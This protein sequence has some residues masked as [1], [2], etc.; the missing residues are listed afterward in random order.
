[1]ENA[2]AKKDI[3]GGRRE[4]RKKAG[5]AYRSTC[6]CNAPYVIPGRARQYI[7]DKNGQITVVDSDPACLFLMQS[8]MGAKRSLHG[9][10]T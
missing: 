5:R 7:R 8:V 10:A 9:F 6:N 4:W 2:A 1:M 3:E